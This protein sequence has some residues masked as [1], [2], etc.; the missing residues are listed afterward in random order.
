MTQQAKRIATRIRAGWTTARAT[1]WVCAVALF[2][3][4]AS[5]A[6]AAEEPGPKGTGDAGLAERFAEV[7]QNTLR[8]K[9]IKDPVWQQ[10]AAMMEA[11]MRLAPAEVRFA[12]LRVEAELGA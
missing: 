3:M 5:A 11:A 7:G 1:G 12:R 10:S 6:P 9:E 2:L 8:V 4:R